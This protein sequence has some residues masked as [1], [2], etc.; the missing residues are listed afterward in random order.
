MKI[1]KCPKT[2]RYIS[3]TFDIARERRVNKS[4]L[5]AEEVIA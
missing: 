1:T 4:D 2:G 5:C 3:G